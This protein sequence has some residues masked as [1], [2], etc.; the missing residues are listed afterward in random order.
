YQNQVSKNIAIAKLGQE[1]SAAVVSPCASRERGDVPDKFRRRVEAL[2]TLIQKVRSWN[3][4]RNCDAFR[5]MF[6]EEG[7]KH[8]I[9]AGRER[10]LTL[11]V[12]LDWGKKLDARGEAGL[13]PNIRKDANQSRK[14]QRRQ[15]D[16]R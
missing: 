1:I 4:T 5:S 12:V 8:R 7:E 3:G 10:P 11:E 16:V 14:L 2:K 13:T 6:S 9:C 15:A